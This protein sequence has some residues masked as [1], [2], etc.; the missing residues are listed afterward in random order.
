M[1]LASVL[2]GIWL[3]LVGLAWAAIISIP[4]V[5][6]GFWALITGVLWLLEAYHPITVFKR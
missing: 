5:F 2:L 1:S 6:L 4:N 3:I